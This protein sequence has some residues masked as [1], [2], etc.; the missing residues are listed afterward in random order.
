MA[1]YLK[2]FELT[3]ILPNPQEEDNEGCEASIQV[4][5]S[6]TNV[7]RV[8]RR[9]GG[10]RRIVSTFVLTLAKA[11][12]LKTFISSYSGQWLELKDYRGRDWRVILTSNPVEFNEHKRYRASVTLEFLGVQL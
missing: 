2:A 6:V 3:C 9:T 1:T 12:E 10:F 4:H 8:Y 7:V 5:T 11:N